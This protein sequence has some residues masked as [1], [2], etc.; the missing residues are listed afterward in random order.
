MPDSSPPASAT[1]LPRVLGPW[2]ATAIVIGTVIGAGV[3]KKPHAVAKDIP[4][5]GII[6]FAWVLVGLFS[7]V[8]S[9]ILA[10]IAIIHPHAGGNY[11]YLREGYG[12]W[13]GFLWG[14]VEFWIIRAGSIA[15]LASVFAET[16]HDI[17]R[18]CL[19]EPGTRADVLGPWALTGVTVAVIA[20]LAFVN[21]RGT[22]IGGGLQV[23]VTTVKVATLLGIAMLPFVC[24]ALQAQPDI[25]AARLEP[26]WPATW[27]SFDWIKFGSALVAILWAYDGWMNLAPMGEEVKEPSRNIPIAF[28][29][30]SL[31]IIVLYVSANVAYHFVVPREVMIREGGSSPVATLF[32]VRLL[33]PTGALLTSVA[34]MISVFGALNGNLLIGPRL[35]FAMGRD[36]LAPRVLCQLHAKYG[37][38]AVAEMV[39]GAWSILLVVAAALLIDFN[40]TQKDKPIFDV[41]TDWVIFGVVVFQTMAIATIFVCRRQYP[42]ERVALPYRSGGYPW[43][44]VLY[45]AANAAVLVSMFVDKPTES[46]I[47][48]GFIA[49]GGAVYLAVFWGRGAPAVVK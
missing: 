42:V 1:K 27:S 47:A 41:L 12:R 44:P 8:G 48:V 32:T 34:I 13:A 35:L 19:N 40:V 4:E 20:V 29:L 16:F 2:M 36:N 28:L 45:I 46:L 30:G 3:F 7:F 37:T 33:G 22:L 9:L 17:L 14:W 25:S 24:L 39:L 21:A 18:Y 38:P 43:L 5:F 31:A 23:V 15:A 26:I 10:E 6:L 49:A 11:V